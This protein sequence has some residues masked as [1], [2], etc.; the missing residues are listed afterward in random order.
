VPGAGCGGSNKI[1]VRM[2][3]RGVGNQVRLHWGW[4]QCADRFRLRV[5]TPSPAAKGRVGP[6]A[7]GTRTSVRITRDA[8]IDRLST[9]V[10]CDEYA[11]P[12]R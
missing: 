7:D 9:E 8:A 5:L 10:A 4:L 11:I 3:S 6:D 12:L 1:R 2:T